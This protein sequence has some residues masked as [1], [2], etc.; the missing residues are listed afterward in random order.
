MPGATMSQPMAVK[1]A[2]NGAYGRQGL[3][4]FLIQLPVDGFSPTQESLIIEVE[5]Y[6]FDDF[7]YFMTGEVLCGHR[8]L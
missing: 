7:L 2:V 8:C 3:N 4:G 6:T 1:Y 5:P